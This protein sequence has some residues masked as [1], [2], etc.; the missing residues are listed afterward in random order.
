MNTIIRKLTIEDLPEILEIEHNVFPDPWQDEAFI[1]ELITN[2]CVGIFDSSNDKLVGYLLGSKV[3]DEFNIDNIAIDIPYQNQ[4]LGRKL[5]ENVLTTLRRESVKY[6][7]LEV[8][9]SNFAG[10]KLYKHF[11]FEQIWLRK[12]YYSHPEENAL[13]MK[14]ILL[15]E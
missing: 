13:I 2:M 7:F 9:E 3:I 5:L 8:R 4:G 15:D 1:Y 10:I 12:N 14:L 6:A 11:G